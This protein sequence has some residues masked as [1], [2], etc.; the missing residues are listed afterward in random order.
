VTRSRHLAP[1][2]LGLVLG[3]IALVVLDRGLA[4][5]EWVSLVRDT[6]V[7]LSLTT[8]LAVTAAVVDDWV[9]DRLRGSGGIR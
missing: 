2:A 7:L 9:E 4:S 5:G 3:W 8:L 6:A 1:A